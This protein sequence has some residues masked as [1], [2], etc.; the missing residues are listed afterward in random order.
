MNEYYLYIL[1][2]SRKLGN[3]DYGLDICFLYEPF[4]I[5]KGKGNRINAHFYPKSLK[6]KNFKNNKIKSIINEGYNVLKE[7]IYTEL[8][9]EEA[10]EKEILFIDKIGRFDIKKGPLTNLTDGKDGS[11]MIVEKTRKPIIKIDI[12]TMS[13]I[14]G[15]SSISEA[16]IKNNTHISNISLCCKGKANTHLGYFWKFKG[17]NNKNLIINKKNRKIL[18]YDYKTG[19]LLNEY[20][21]IGEASKKT[22]IYS[23]YITICCQNKIK[24]LNGKY[25]RYKDNNFEKQEKKKT[26]KKVILIKNNKEIIFNSIKE[27]AEYLNCT[28]KCIW[29]SCKNDNIHNHEIYYESDYNNGIR[30]IK[31]KDKK[32]KQIIVKDVYTLEIFNFDSITNASNTLNINRKTIE[33]VI[34]RNGVYKNK[35]QF[36]LKNN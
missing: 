14:D 32:R 16:A 13:E 23:S 1:Y 20:N 21:S 8:I 12:N 29:E 4:Y 17:D 26:F 15:Y 3:F 25:F 35:Y 18:E 27:C 7:K 11:N 34:K 31:L 30:K 10:F 36:Q 9:Q 22:C 5:G 19:E 28:V 2:D 24:E 33:R 6:S